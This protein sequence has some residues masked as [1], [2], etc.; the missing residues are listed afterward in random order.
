MAERDNVLTDIAVIQAEHGD[1]KKA[2]EIAAKIRNAL[3]RANALQ[4]LATIKAASEDI[5]GALQIAET[6]EDH[7][8]SGLAFRR[9]ALLQWRQG[10]RSGGQETLQR[11]LAEVQSLP[12]RAGTN[13]IALQEIGTAL[14]E[15]GDSNAARQVFRQARQ[16][17]IRYDDEAY[18]AVLLRGVAKSQAKNGLTEDLAV[19]IKK[20]SPPAVKAWTLLGVAEGLLERAECRRR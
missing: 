14:V 2:L 15:V 16:S 4:E 3:G 12:E 8:L 19:W 18:R 1:V 11:A 13:V 7:Y 20:L 6:I 9:I 5:N 17:A 10:N